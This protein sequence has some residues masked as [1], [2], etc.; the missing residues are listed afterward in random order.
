MLVVTS[1]VCDEKNGRKNLDHLLFKGETQ[2]LVFV[3]TLLAC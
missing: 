2:M 1:I 3:I